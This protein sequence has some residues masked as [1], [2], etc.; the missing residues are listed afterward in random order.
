MAGFFSGIVIQI[1]ISIST[2]QFFEQRAKVKNNL[3][4]VSYVI[5]MEF[6]RRLV[7]HAYVQSQLE[8]VNEHDD[9]A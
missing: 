6:L 7:M 2:R 8:I 3:L 4:V 5:K 1:A 9:E